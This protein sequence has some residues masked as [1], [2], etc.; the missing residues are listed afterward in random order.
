MG[1]LSL[2]TLRKDMKE[3]YGISKEESNS[4]DRRD[5]WDMKWA[6]DNPSYL[7]VMERMR[8]YV[9]KDGSPEE[10]ITSSAYIADFQ[11][12]CFIKY[13]LATEIFLILGEYEFYM[14]K[15]H[16]RKGSVLW[17]CSYHNYGCYTR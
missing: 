9:L 10:P 15:I 7:A 6:T 14:E 12:R 4:A 16:G 17:I 13:N 5:V 8:M 1:V 11:V 2:I 3:N